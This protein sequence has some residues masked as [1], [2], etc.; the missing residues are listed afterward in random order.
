MTGDDHDIRNRL[1]PRVELNPNLLTRVKE[2]HRNTSGQIDLTN[3]SMNTATCCIFAGDACGHHSKLVEHL[4]RTGEVVRTD[5][6]FTNT[7][8]FLYI[9]IGSLLEDEQTE[10][11]VTLHDHGTFSGERLENDEWKCHLLLQE[12]IGTVLTAKVHVFPD[13]VFLHRSRRIGSN[14]CF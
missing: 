5:R 12:R 4:R 10:E 3:Y 11:P 7:E 8:D 2:H 14:Q 6:S 13:A 1:S 9:L